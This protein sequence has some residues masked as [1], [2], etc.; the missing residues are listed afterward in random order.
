LKRPNATISVDVDPVDLHLAG[1]GLDGGAPDPLAYTLALPRLIEVFDRVGVRATFFV[2][3]RDA[4]ANA[5]PIA[6]VAA[7]GHEIGSH[8]FSHPFAFAQLSPAAKRDEL[9]ASR[10]VLESASGASV[11]GFRAPNFDLDE[12]GIVSLIEAGFRYDASSYPTPM[13]LPARV[14]MAVKGGDIPRTLRLRCWPFSFDREPHRW[15]YGHHSLIEFPL[16]VSRGLRL[17]FYHTARYYLP[18]SRFQTIL[19][20]LADEGVPLSYP[21]HAVDAL[22]LSEDRVDPRLKPHPGMARPLAGKLRLLEVSLKSIAAR[23]EVA[24]FGERVAAL[25]ASERML[26][27]PLPAA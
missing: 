19:D 22:G 12:R 2:V 18:E 14:L 16:S 21:L 11:V 20:E 25:E 15:V 6:Q 5:K 26:E 10:N 7:A 4:Q 13:L 24:T 27:R 23:Y 9:I 3:G 8:T 1:Y 17:P